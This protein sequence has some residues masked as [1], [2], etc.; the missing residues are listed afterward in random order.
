MYIFRLSHISSDLSATFSLTRVLTRRIFR[1][2]LETL[3]YIF[4]DSHTHILQTPTHVRHMISHVCSLTHVLW[5]FRDTWRDSHI[6]LKLPHS[7]SSD[8]HTC[9]PHNISRVFSH[10]HLMHVSRC[11]TGLSHVFLDSHTYILYT[12]T[13]VRHMISHT[14]SLTHIWY[15]F[16]DTCRISHIYL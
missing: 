14:C 15:M 1:H 5:M 11:M 13:H 6:Y 9:S 12:S 4:L 10:T 8:S 2:T 3:T 7:H 16:R